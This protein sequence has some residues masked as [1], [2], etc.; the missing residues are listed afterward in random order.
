MYVTFYGAVREVTGSMH[1]LCTEKDR[2]LMD[3]GLFQGHRRSANE[4]NRVIPFDPRILTNMVLSHAHVDHSGRIPILVRDG[5]LGRVYC[6]RPTASACEYLLL[7]SAHIQENDAEYLNYKTA[8]AALSRMRSNDTGKN[9]KRDMQEIKAI[10]KKGKNGLNAETINHYIKQL[11]LESV[12]PLY[13]VA[14][15]ERALPSIEGIPYRTPM[16]IG[17]DTTVTFYEAGHILG[18]AIV[19]IR[20]ENNGNPKTVCFSGDIGRYDKPILRNP[21]SQFKPEHHNVDLMILES[22]YGNRDHAPVVDMR[23][24][25]KQALVDNYNRGG[26]ILIPSFAYGRTQELLYVLHE[27]YDSNEVP[28]L[29]IYVDS[30]LATNITKV[31]G[32]HPEVYDQ[33]THRKFLQQGKNPFSFRQVS[34]VESVEASMDLMRDERPHIVI[35][36]SGMCEAGRILHHLRYKIH[37]PKSTILIVGYMA[38][39]TLGRRIMEKAAAYEAAGRTGEPPMVKILNK[40][41]PLKARVIRLGGFSAHGDRHEMLRFLQSSGLS[42]KQIALVHGEEDQSLAFADFLK[43]AGFAAKVPQ[44]G[45]T[46]TV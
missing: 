21:A 13:T 17:Q 22:T 8:R 28:R 25:L 16:T 12:E 40:E 29:P 33:E 5:F 39:N 19:M 14:D 4:K 37:D 1:L 3:C 31:F 44:L 2:I 38:A 41:Y 11:R 26:S 20:C 23:P 27:L 6:T 10:L 7:D 18:S 34:F 15:A 43:N 42:I 24:Q 9:G 35:S 46:W 30:P 45:E 36:A 32:E